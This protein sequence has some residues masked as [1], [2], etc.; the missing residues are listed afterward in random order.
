MNSFTHRTEHYYG[1]TRNITTVSWKGRGEVDAELIRDWCIATFGK[2]GY[3]EETG[4]TAWVDNSEC[5][6][7]MLCNDADLTMFLLR[8]E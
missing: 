7:I 6:E 5:E 2:S 1:S 8:W 4:D 3:R